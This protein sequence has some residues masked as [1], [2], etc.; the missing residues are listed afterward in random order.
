MLCHASNARPLSRR[1][2]HDSIIQC[3]LPIVVC[4]GTL[5]SLLG[6][7]ELNTVSCNEKV[8]SQEIVWYYC[9]RL[10]FL[11]AILCFSMQKKCITTCV[12][13]FLH[14]LLFSCATVSRTLFEIR[15]VN[16]AP[17]SINNFVR[18][19]NLF[20]NKNTSLLTHGPT[21]VPPR[22]YQSIVG[23]FGVVLVFLSASFFQV[24][25]NMYECFLFH[26]SNNKRPIWAIRLT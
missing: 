25:D 9:F 3:E 18:F 11:Y 12:Q 7:I 4:P 5:A 13:I 1:F 2:A 6:G 21:C 17:V 16:D 20:L 26:R 14:T 23:F 10:P 15:R 22:H 19:I 24:L 8:P